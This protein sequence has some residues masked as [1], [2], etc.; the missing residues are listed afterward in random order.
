MI[1][2]EMMFFFLVM[3]HMGVR[4]IWYRWKMLDAEHWF[5]LLHSKKFGFLV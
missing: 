4:S 2:V 1:H 3:E 5:D